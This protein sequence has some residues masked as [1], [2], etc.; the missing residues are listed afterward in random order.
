[1]SDA[2]WDAATEVVS[3]IALTLPETA[4]TDRRGDAVWSVAGKAFAWMRRFSK[5][6][7]KRFGDQT[8]PQGP[9]LAVR[10]EDE[11]EKQAVLAS[12]LDGIFT[13][14][15]FDGFAAVL[16]ELDEVSRDDLREAVVSAW[17]AMAP[18][19]LSE[20]FAP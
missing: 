1:M 15:H 13:I 16:I 11:G 20:N 7:I 19:R 6:D 17:L 9:I 10:V 18:A 14:P 12:N 2:D 4:V 3:D 5:A 8:P